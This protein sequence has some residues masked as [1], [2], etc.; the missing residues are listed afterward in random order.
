MSTPNQADHSFFR[1]EWGRLEQVVERF[2]EAWQRGERPAIDEYLAAEGVEPRELIL[3]L[4]HADLESRLKAGEAAR[5]EAYFGRYAG[6]AQDRAGALRLIEAEY[7]LR[8]RRE[9]GLGPAEYLRR[10]PQY[11]EDLMQ[12]FQGPH[13]LPQP[14]PSPGDAAA[15]TDSTAQTKRTD[16][17]GGDGSPS[18][19][20]PSW[21]GSFELLRVIGQGAFGTVYRARDAHLGRIVAVKLP[22]ADQSVSPADVERFLREARS[23]AGLSHPGIVPVYEVGRAEGLPYIVSAYVEGFT[24]AETLARHRLDARAAALV[25]AQAAEA[26]D[27]AH[28]HGVVHRDLKPSNI[29]LGRI[30]GSVTWGERSA[31]DGLTEPSPRAFVMDFGLARREEGEARLTVEGQILGT[32]AYMSP[33]Q[34]DG[35]GHRVDGRSDVY[36]LGVILYELLTG[37]LP[38]RGTTRMV[39]QQILDEEPGPPRRLNDKVPR[40]LETITLQC[41][42]KEPGR[43]Y[44]TAGALA[45]DLRRHLRGEPVLARPV[46]PVERCWRWAKRS[47]WV[48]GLGAAVLLLLVAVAVGSVVAIVLIDRQRQATEES[49]AAANERLDLALEALDR[50]IADIQEQLRDQMRV[51]ESLLQTAAEGLERV[52]RSSGGAGGNRGLASAQQRL[53]DVF[54]ELGRTAQARE[55][56]ERCRSLVEALAARD[57]NNPEHKRALCVVTAKLG[58]VSRR[59]GDAA[60]AGASCRE[61]LRLAQELAEASPGKVPALRD[62]GR[63]YDLVGKASLQLGDA[64]AAADCH[65]KAAELGQQVVAADPEDPQARKELGAAYF[66]LGDATLRADNLPAA[67]AAYGKAREQYEAWVAAQPKSAQPRRALALTWQKLGDVELWARDAR[68]ARESYR[69]ALARLEELAAADPDNSLFR[70]DLFAAYGKLGEISEQLGDAPAARDFHRKALDRLEQLE[71]R[72]PRDPRAGKQIAVAY[73]TLGKLSRALGELQATHQY[74]REAVARFEAL[75]EANPANALAQGDLAA[76]YGS[77]GIALMQAHDYAG[78]AESFERGVATL[79]G[80]EAQGKLA[81]QP[82]YRGWLRDQRQGLGFCRAAQ[83]AADDLDFALAMRPPQAKPLL[84]ARAAVL[85]HRGRHAEA[86]ATAEKLRELDA[87]D[88]TNLYNV[89][90]CYALCAAGVAPGKPPGAFSPEESAARTRYAARALEH[91]GRAVEGGYGDTRRIESDPDLAAVRAEKGYAQLVGRLRDGSGGRGE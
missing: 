35:R 64:R 72:H 54:L 60:A 29:M 6:L 2:E 22:R 80:L 24:L 9:P 59:E 37:E 28:R 77:A 18:G 1:G 69:Q 74:H 68:A 20:G 11:R 58:E 70:R 12:L 25:V 46:T 36:S 86:A 27:H 75:A 50:L 82:D 81:D 57:P 65:G 33:E 79:Q 62:L 15:L 16:P 44:A 66:N 61:A 40:D 4:A 71:G 45:A 38:F 41:L 42:A 31:A 87:A 76:A 89:A 10:F 3:E 21:L 30:Q 49:A 51:K 52:A 47:P 78:A 26:L 34:A 23:A 91:L 63:C 56:Y 5:V 48:A 13:L 8:R 19:T 32:P 67:R 84:A 88:P 85:A 43:R 90:C 55:H 73:L 53:G 39:L 83:R 17:S 14:P 7:R